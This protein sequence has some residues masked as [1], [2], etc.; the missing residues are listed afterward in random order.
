[1]TLYV[2][3]KWPVQFSLAQHYAMFISFLN[4]IRFS[5][6]VCVIKLQAVVENF[7]LNILVDLN[8]YHQRILKSIDA[9]LIP[10][11]G[12]SVGFLAV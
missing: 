8:A 2:L 11:I 3:K 9:Y 7:I 1:M 4:V 6:L 5:F 10:S 12:C